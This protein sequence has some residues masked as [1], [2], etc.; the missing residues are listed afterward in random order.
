MLRIQKKYKFNYHLT[1]NPNSESIPGHTISFTSYPASIHSQ[2]D[3]YQINLNKSSRVTVAGT[4]LNFGPTHIREEATE[5]VQIL[6]ICL[7]LRNGIYFSIFFLAGLQWSKSY[8]CQSFVQWWEIVDE[9]HE[10]VQHWFRP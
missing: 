1:G 5:Q 7:Q 10:N 6:N 8:G 9:S 2:D 4:A 3:F